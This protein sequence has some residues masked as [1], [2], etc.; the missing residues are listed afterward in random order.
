[1]WS[2]WWHKSR[3]NPESKVGSSTLHFSSK[4]LCLHWSYR[5]KPCC[6]WHSVCLTILKLQ[7]FHHQAI[8][9]DM[10]LIQVDSQDLPLFDLPLY[11]QELFGISLKDSVKGFLAG[12]DSHFYP[13]GHAHGSHIDFNVC[14]AAGLWKS[15]YMRAWWGICWGSCIVRKMEINRFLDFQV[16][17]VD[18]T[19]LCRFVWM[20]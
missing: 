2:G 6:P 9:Q 5:A 20:L 18:I 17:K 8:C 1:M 11:L 10:A 15:W 16:F 4:S 7:I 19:L 3:V 12:L 14:S 13:G